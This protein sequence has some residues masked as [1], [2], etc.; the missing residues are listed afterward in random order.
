VLTA[1][2]VDEVT[3]AKAARKYARQLLRRLQEAGLQIV[4]APQVSQANLS[5]QEI[6]NTYAGPRDRFIVSLVVG[7]QKENGVKSPKHAVAAAL[8]LTTDDMQ[9]ETHWWCFDRKTGQMHLIMQGDA[10]PL[11]DSLVFQ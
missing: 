8:L 6:G 10:E 4:S 5:L 1:W 3:D 7:Y 9:C 11:K 2:H